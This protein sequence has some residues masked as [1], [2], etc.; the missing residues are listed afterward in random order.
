VNTPHDAFFSKAFS[1]AGRARELVRVALPQHIAARLNL[2]SLVVS[3]GSYVSST[4][5]RSSSDLLL[6]TRT[7]GRQPLLLY[8]L[9]EHKS[10]PDR[11]TLYQL[12]RYMV[13]IWDAWSSRKENRRWRFLPPIIPIIFSHSRRRW[14]YPLGFAALVRQPPGV[15]LGPFTPSFSALLLDLAGREDS[16]LGHDKLV[17]AL[18]QLLKHIQAGSLHAL[19]QALAAMSEL[20]IA[21]PEAEL[22]KA[23]LTYLLRARHDEPVGSILGAL[24]GSRFRRIAMTIADRLERKGRKEG[25]IDE[26]QELLE[27]QLERKFGLTERERKGIRS[28][29]DPK[30]LDAALDAILFADSKDVVLAH[31]R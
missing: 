25:R 22:L 21:K 18:L 29:R 17:K 31:L 24:P 27:R 9:F 19:A 6:E 5:R 7:R 15:D 8:I 26:K 3:R 10:S 2:E 16:E 28:R 20:D 12:L 4:L 1:N 13:G 11:R 23:A 30:Q 14:T